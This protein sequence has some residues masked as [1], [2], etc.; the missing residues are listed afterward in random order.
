MMALLIGGQMAAAMLEGKN[1]NIDINL[2]EL[3]NKYNRKIGLYAFDANTRAT[4]AYNAN[5]R[6]PFQ[7]TF[8][9]VA[10][11]AF[12]FQHQKAPMLKDKIT[13]K[14]SDIVPWGPISLQYL[15]ASINY[16]RLCE[17]AIAY[18]DNTA[19]NLII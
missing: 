18:S 10:V 2:V 11:A 13:I 5:K 9:L 6:F 1:I 14:P 19:I 15:N 16:N 7:S 8:R 4:I 3:E 17:A 12:L